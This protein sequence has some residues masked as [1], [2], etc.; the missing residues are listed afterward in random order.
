M[1]RTELSYKENRAEEEGWPR[2]KGR[3]GGGR[4]RSFWALTPVAL[5]A[6]FVS[7]QKQELAEEGQK[8]LTDVDHCFTL[9]ELCVARS[10]LIGIR[11]E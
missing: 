8:L 2:G 6:P 9:R 1:A 3:G 5:R 10:E 11:S 7:A 4:R